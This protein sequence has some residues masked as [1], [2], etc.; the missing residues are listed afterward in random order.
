M[1]SPLLSGGNGLDGD[2]GGRSDRGGRGDVARRRSRSR[3]VSLPGP[4]QHRVDEGLVR[5]GVRVGRRQAGSPVRFGGE[6]FY[7][8]VGGPDLHWPRALGAQPCLCARYSGVL[9][10]RSSIP[11]IISSCSP[12]SLA[13]NRRA[14]SRWHPATGG[15][16]ASTL[17]ASS[18]A[19]SSSPSNS[20]T[21]TAQPPM[22]GMDIH[23]SMTVRI[24]LLCNSL[25]PP[26]V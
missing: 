8:E 6:S 19:S 5:L 17:A 23:Q 7:G 3:P 26:S 21:R 11:S 22:Y 14:H 16:P 9:L 20:R 4:F 13:S 24:V 2:A 12:R 25:P 1:I 10:R 18:I 15:R